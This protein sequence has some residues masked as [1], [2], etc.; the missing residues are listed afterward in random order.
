MKPLALPAESKWRFGFLP[1]PLG[2]KK[3][4]RDVLPQNGELYLITVL[5]NAVVVVCLNAQKAYPPGIS[6]ILAQGPPP[7][8]RTHCAYTMRHT[9]RSQYGNF[10]VSQQTCN[11]K[12]LAESTMVQ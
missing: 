11:M 1:Y 3:P 12:A 7:L 9:A 2:T 6:Y 4:Q 8:Q 5:V 10:S